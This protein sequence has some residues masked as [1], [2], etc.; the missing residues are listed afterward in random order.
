MG[1]Q[2]SYDRVALR[3]DLLDREGFHHAFFTRKGGVSPAPWSSLNFAAS[4][5]DSLDHVRGNLEIAG[6][7]LRA[8]PERIYFLSQ[9]HG[10]AVHVLEGDEDRTE[11]ILHQGDATLSKAPQVVCGVR[12]ADCATL[13]LGDLRTGAVSA[14]HAG[15]RG[16]VRGVVESAIVAMR[17]LTGQDVEIVAAI[18]PHI[19]VCCF[20]VGDDVAAEL[21][22]SSRLG[23]R[24]VRRGKNASGETQKAHVDLRAILEDNLV[25]LGVRRERIDHVRGCTLCDTETFFSYRREGQMSGRM[26]SAIAVRS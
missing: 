16:T 24:A 19:E 2:P 18:G 14:V 11:V 9:V 7:E 23:E 1:T 21:A 8:E 5:G 10:T 20:E 3:S 26:L 22:L 15:W 13:L 25:A 17:E 6:A 4:T 12:S